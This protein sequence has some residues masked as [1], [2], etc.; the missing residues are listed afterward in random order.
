LDFT[1]EDVQWARE[2][3][4]SPERTAAFVRQ[5][6]ENRDDLGVIDD[7]LFVH[8]VLNGRAK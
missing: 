4:A 8:E 1:P 3:I 5:Y 7:M 2:I 6:H